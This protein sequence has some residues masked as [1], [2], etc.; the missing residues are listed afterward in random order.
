M[1]EELGKCWKC[2]KQEAVKEVYGY[3]VCEDCAEDLDPEGMEMVVI[4]A[5]GRDIED[6]E[7]LDEINERKNQNE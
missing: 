2:G 1:K 7:S 6:I 5:L 3:P 4:N